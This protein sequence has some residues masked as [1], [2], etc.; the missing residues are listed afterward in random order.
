MISPLRSLIIDQVQKLKTL[1]VSSNSLRYLV[2]LQISELE[3]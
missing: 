2:K 1:D 3:I